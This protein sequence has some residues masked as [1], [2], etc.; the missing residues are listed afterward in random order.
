MDLPGNLSVSDM[1]VIAK[2]G[3]PFI[4]NTVSRLAGLGA[5][6][7]KKLADDGVPRWAVATLAL[8]V[9]AAVGARLYKSYPRKFPAWV[10][11]E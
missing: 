9:G 3:S 8:V 2:E 10:V 1:M 6:E 4:V 11:G 7:R 5:D